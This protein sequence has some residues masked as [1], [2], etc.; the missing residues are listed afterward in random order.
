MLPLYQFTEIFFIDHQTGNKAYFKRR[1]NQSIEAAGNYGKAA[2]T[3]GLWDGVGAN[4]AYS[5]QLLLCDSSFYSGFFVSGY[6][7]SCY[8]Q[9]SSWCSD[10]STPFFRTASTHSKF[11]GVAFNKNGAT[12]LGNRLISVGAR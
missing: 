9:C 3:H 1:V 8:K 11:K 4:S 12:S 6:T 2:G 5:Y 7:G 10:F